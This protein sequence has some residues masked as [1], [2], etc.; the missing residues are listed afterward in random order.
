MRMNKEAR[1]KQAKQKVLFE[2]NM[3]YI[4]DVY[5]MPDFIE[6]HGRSGGEDVCFRVY[7]NGKI[8]ER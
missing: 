6:V 7:N 4:I 5:E 8:Y 1:L 2:T 3:D